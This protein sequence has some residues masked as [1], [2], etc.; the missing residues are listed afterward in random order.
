M[1]TSPEHGEH[2]SIA[3]QFKQKLNHRFAQ[4]EPHRHAPGMGLREEEIHLGGDT[5]LIAG[6]PP[7]RI[8]AIRP[9][10]GD[11]TRL[12]PRPSDFLKGH[13][14]DMLQYSSDGYM[15]TEIYLK[16]GQIRQR[17]TYREKTPTASWRIPDKHTGVIQHMRFILPSP[18]DFRQDS[19]LEP[20]AIA[21]L[22]QFLE[23]ASP[24]APPEV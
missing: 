9:K 10:P 6:A 17:V 12:K 20:E 13:R 4:G 2:L 18:N 15:V 24:T 1:P 5:S 21:S 19:V 16:D 8:R 23:T 3:E 14:L 22:F 7:Q 11:T